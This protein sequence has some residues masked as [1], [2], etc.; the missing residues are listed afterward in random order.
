M[1]A[2]STAEVSR[3]V[4]LSSEVSFWFPEFI[5]E[6]DIGFLIWDPGSNSNTKVKPFAAVNAKDILERLNNNDSKDAT[7]SSILA[8]M[9]LNNSPP[10]I[11]YDQV[12]F[13][14]AI[15]NNLPRQEFPNSFPNDPGYIVPLFAATKKGLPLSDIDFVLGGSALEFLA[16]RRVEEGT[17][18]LVQRMH[19]VIFLVKSKA[20]VANYADPGFQFERLVT[21]GKLEDKHSPLK[22]EHLQVM[23]IGRNA[24]LFSAEV[25]AVDDAGDCV[26]IKSGNPRYFGT[27]VMFQMISSGAQTLVQGEKRG[28]VFTGVRNRSIS[29]MCRE[30]PRSELQRMQAS[31]I[32]TLNELKEMASKISDELPSELV[33][34]GNAIAFRVVRSNVSILPPKGAIEEL[35]DARSKKLS[36]KAKGGEAEV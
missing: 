1:A 8:K 36:S 4:P 29:D 6:K 17:R 14:V 7:V 19:N 23:K 13:P 21:G 20:Y 11:N 2:M 30:H 31:I 16:H 26:E 15:R 32:K 33:F 25:D 34:S 35:F 28:S 27:K 10:T 24:V 12:R 22:H 18:Y 9:S 5:R 3:S